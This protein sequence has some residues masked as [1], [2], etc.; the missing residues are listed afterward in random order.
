MVKYKIEFNITPLLGFCESVSRSGCII[1][2]VHI[3]VVN[4]NYPSLQR[5][6]ENEACLFCYKSLLILFVYSVRWAFS[7][8]SNVSN[9]VSKATDYLKND[10]PAQAAI[11][12]DALTVL[13]LAADN[14]RYSKLSK[15]VSLH[16][17]ITCKL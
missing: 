11:V 10:Q 7:L 5:S 4:K 13:L 16:Q 1:Y 17:L 3:K 12:L 15:S 8:S 2:A 6:N 9:T 14:D